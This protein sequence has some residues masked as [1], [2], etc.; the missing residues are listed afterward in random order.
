MAKRNRETKSTEPNVTQSDLEAVYDT[1][2]KQNRAFNTRPTD[3]KPS[4]VPLGSN[5][6]PAMP[7]QIAGALSYDNSPNMYISPGY[8][9]LKDLSILKDTQ[10]KYN[11]S[12][13]EKAKENIYNLGLDHTDPSFMQAKALMDQTIDNFD[14]ELKTG[15]WSDN[16]DRVKNF[17]QDLL[18]KKGGKQFLAIKQ[19]AAENTKALGQAVDDYDPET[20]TDGIRQDEVN[21]YSQPK[22]KPFVFDKDGNVIGGGQVSYPKVYKNRN[23]PKEIDGILKNTEYFSDFGTVNEDGERV[24]FVNTDMFGKY[25]IEK[26]KEVTPERIKEAA[27]SYLMATGGYE[28]IKRQGEIK[29]FNNPISVDEAREKLKALSEVDGQDENNPY[30]T[31]LGT[32]DSELERQLRSGLG[33][34]LQTASLRS[35]LLSGAI[36]KNSYTQRDIEFVND[37][38]LQHAENARVDSLYKKSKSGSGDGDGYEAPEIKPYSVLGYTISTYETLDPTSSVS[39]QGKKQALGTEL[40]SLNANL[41]EMK[42][43]PGYEN[44]ANY[45]ALTQR[46]ADID[47]ELKILNETDKQNIKYFG[48]LIKESTKVGLYSSYDNYAGQAKFTSGKAQPVSRDTYNNAIASAI[49]AYSD[50]DPR[51]SPEE[52]L[53]NAGI[54]TSISFDGNRY[55]NNVRNSGLR[56]YQESSKKTISSGLGY[57]S[58]TTGEDYNSASLLGIVTKAGERLK[59]KSKEKGTSNTILKDTTIFSLEGDVEKHP[60]S[61]RFANAEKNI[62]ELVKNNLETVKVFNPSGNP[63]NDLS[64]VSALSQQTGFEVE[65]ISK[66]LYLSAV[67]LTTTQSFGKDKGS[68]YVASFKYKPVKE[69]EEPTIY[70]LQEELRSKKGGTDNYAIRFT[71]GPNQKGVDAEMQVALKSLLLTNRESILGMTDQAKERAALALGNMDGTNS[72]VD[73]IHIYNLDGS[74]RN[75]SRSYRD[76]NF[77]GYKLRI[78][79][80]DLPFAKNAMDK[81]FTV[82]V[83][84]NGQYKSIGFLNGE[85]GLFTDDELKQN[86]NIVKKNFDTDLDIKSYLNLLKLKTETN[87]NKGGGGNNEVDITRSGDIRADKSNE[88]TTTVMRNGREYKTTTYVA[89]ND[90]INISGKVKLSENSGIPYVHKDIA[91]N[92]V[93]TLSKYGLTMTGGLRTKEHSPKGGVENSAHFNG[94]AIDIKDDNNSNK[95]YRALRSTPGLAK[96]LGITF[97][98]DHNAGTG[99]HLHITFLPKRSNFS[100]NTNMTGSR[101]MNAIA[102]GES[103]NRNLGYHNTDKSSAYGKYGF[104]NEWI[105]RISKFYNKPEQEIRKNPDLIKQYANTE[106]LKIAT[107]E[108][109]PYFSKLKQKA[110]RYIPNFSKEDAIFMYHYAGINFLKEVAN[111]TK[112]IYDIPRADVGNTET[113]KEYVMKKRKYL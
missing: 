66:A 83:E 19:A 99:E 4:V 47:A 57:G 85:A 95:F 41:G 8:G 81:D 97:Y 102:Q 80:R 71:L 84:D 93:N 18:N 90:L 40:T 106:Y 70:K 94:Y 6:T 87:F 34:T 13:W 77:S 28:Y 111:G 109:N 91:D 26:G 3:W 53:N 42:K 25:G 14:N 32:D 52:I 61:K 9:E 16:E 45:Q 92:V 75:P 76:V 108:I 74:G 27:E 82:Q 17:T 22:L 100:M 64:L 69:S 10:G 24:M 68:V 78:N 50:D 37:E 31:L 60:E 38:V 36:A 20:Q 105:N 107:D 112:S 58:I 62:Y 59:E 51:T 72:A 54:G 39:I 43:I 7:M 30:L 15:L 11:K 56:N 48:D 65:D 44:D 55:I 33:N 46:K 101:I 67:K 23:L 86:P 21:F 79:A 12:A 5:Q 63:A 113:L 110:G 103:S 29:E 49:V 88:Y 2:Y 89:P 104:T 35:S 73:M 98:L 96:D 1:I